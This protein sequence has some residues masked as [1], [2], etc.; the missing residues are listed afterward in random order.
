MNCVLP[1]PC[2]FDTVSLAQ[3]R[4]CD[5][6]SCICE[7]HK[8]FFGRAARSEDLSRNKSHC[9]CC[10]GR[11]NPVTPHSLLCVD[12]L[13]AWTLTQRPCFICINPAQWLCQHLRFGPAFKQLLTSLQNAAKALPIRTGG[14][15]ATSVLTSLARTLELRALRRIHTEQELPLVAK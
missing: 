13:A 11:Q 2:G 3:K 9:R 14:K 15:R 4:V 7:Q 8:Q 5:A 10:C 1:H 12:G 6:C